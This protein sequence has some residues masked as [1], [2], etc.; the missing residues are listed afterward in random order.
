MSDIKSPSPE[1]MF[2]EET[3][4]LNLFFQFA[5][6]SPKCKEYLFTELLEFEEVPSEEAKLSFKQAITWT[7]SKVTK[8]KAVVAKQFVTLTKMVKEWKLK[9]ELFNF[10]LPTAKN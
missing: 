3:D 7:E 1:K 6:K 9:P 8:H 5:Q 10:L 2:S 4:L